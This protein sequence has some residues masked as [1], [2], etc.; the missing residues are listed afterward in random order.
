MKQILMVLMVVSAVG[1]VIAGTCTAECPALE[2]GWIACEGTGKTKSEAVDDAIKHGIAMVYG[3]VLK[4]ED[5]VD[6]ASERRTVDNDGDQKTTE[7][8]L[9]T[10]LSKIETKTAGIVRESRTIWCEKKGG[11][12]SVGG[13]YE[14]HVHA[15]IRSPRAGVQ[16]VVFVAPAYLKP[17]D[18]SLMHSTGPKRRISG[19]ELSEKVGNAIVAILHNGGK[20]RVLTTKDAMATDRNREYAAKLAMAGALGASEVLLFSQR[21]AADFALT[22]SI[23]EVKFSK[24]L[25]LDK[26]TG[27]FGTV[28]SFTADVNLHLA[29]VK[30]GAVAGDKTLRLSVPSEAIAK[31]VEADEDADLLT[32]AV[33]LISNNV[34]EFVRENAK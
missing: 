5:K 33:D 25:G 23:D 34:L 13:L 24:K 15:H 27:K 4:A 1:A 26:K 18:R 12:L 21:L 31:A 30:T 9:E 11:V 6:S 8:S 29:N 28:Y 14:A 3:E 2:E 22:V 20:F 16:A 10:T 17:A 19:V 32:F 7:T